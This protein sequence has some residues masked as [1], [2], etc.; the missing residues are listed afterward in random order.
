MGILLWNHALVAVGINNSSTIV[1]HDR[2][3][4]KL[5]PVTL[6]LM[7]DAWMPTLAPNPPRQIRTS[8]YMVVALPTRGN[9][10]TWIAVSVWNTRKTVVN[11]W[12]TTWAPQEMFTCILATV[13]QTKNGLSL[14]VSG[15]VKNHHLQSKKKRQLEN[16]YSVYI[17]SNYVYTYTETKKREKSWYIFI[18]IVSC[19]NIYTLT[20]IIILYNTFSWENSIACQPKELCASINYS[21]FE[22]RAAVFATPTTS[23]RLLRID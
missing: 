22:L 20:C 10:G 7:V 14:P 15:T 2:Y 18:Y 11:A 19:S 13:I 12:T 3:E 1:I 21:A 16:A 8:T 23:T 4:P 5:V 17:T 9:G 6:V